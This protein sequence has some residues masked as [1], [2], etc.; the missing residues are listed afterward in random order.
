MD[1]ELYLAFK[2]LYLSERDD[3]VNDFL[4]LIEQNYLPRIQKNQM[5]IDKIKKELEKN[6]NGL[7]KFID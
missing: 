5:E 2:D 1:H 3:L 6:Q 7:Y 4:S